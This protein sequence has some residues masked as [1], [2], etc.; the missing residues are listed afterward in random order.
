L[1]RDKIKRSEKSLPRTSLRGKGKTVL[2]T[3]IERQA[4][5]DG[6]QTIF[7]EVHED[8]TL[9]PLIASHHGRSLFDREGHGLISFTRVTA[10]SNYVMF[11]SHC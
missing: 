8:Q 10:S 9:G 2:L 7:L 6:Y 5:S 3:E 11:V 4:R 1:G